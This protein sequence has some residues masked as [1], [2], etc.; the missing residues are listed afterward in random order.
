VGYGNRPLP[1]QEWHR[2]TAPASTRPRQLAPREAEHRALAF[3]ALG[4]DPSPSTGS[5]TTC[6]RCRLHSPSASARCPTTKPPSAPTPACSRPAQGDQL[7]LSF[8]TRLLRA[9]GRSIARATDAPVELYPSTAV[10]SSC[11]TR[12]LFRA[13]GAVVAIVGSLGFSSFGCQQ[14]R[15]RPRAA[16]TTAVQAAANH[17]PGCQAAAGPP[18]G[19]SP[20]LCPAPKSTCQEAAPAACERLIQAC[21]TPKAC[22]EAWTPIA[23]DAG[24]GADSACTDRLVRQMT[25]GGDAIVPALI[26]AART[27]SD[28]AR[29]ILEQTFVAIRPWRG[30]LVASIAAEAPVWLLAHVESKDTAHQLLL[31][32]HD[33]AVRWIRDGLRSG[34]S[35][36]HFYSARFVAARLGS[37]EVIPTMTTVIRD[38]GLRGRS[39]MR[40]L[41]LMERHAI[42]PAIAA[43]LVHEDW[44][45]V[46]E[47]LEVAA[48]TRPAGVRSELRRVAESHWS[49]RLRGHASGVLKLLEGPSAPTPDF[50][51][52]RF[53]HG[54]AHCVPARG[55][56]D[57][58]RFSYRGQV[59][60]R[61]AP[62]WPEPQ[63]PDGFPEACLRSR[64]DRGS[65]HEFPSALTAS[66]AVP[67][68]WLAVVN[69]G[70]W[71]GHVLFVAKD[72]TG[73]ELPNA[74]P[75]DGFVE[76]PDGLLGVYGSCH[77]NCTIGYV[78]RLMQ[79]GGKWQVAQTTTLP[80]VAR[81][82]WR[83]DDGTVLVATEAGIVH[84][85][86]TGTFDFLG[87]L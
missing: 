50:D 32:R 4:D 9:D 33:E 52:S 26:A 2:Q 80:N 56:G 11:M 5:T 65:W 34:S 62:A 42:M 58:W 74:V 51:H 36:W 13:L 35:R 77:G 45:M 84:L 46:L 28:G 20:G 16:R 54:Y 17:V 55:T 57:V 39:I 18:I 29:D 8:R 25:A 1:P 48:A 15:P 22:V 79:R 71:G 76:A 24:A 85:A 59:E 14:P 53:D 69:N 6:D 61:R 7:A 60:V 49:P 27:S 38:G 43:G 63:V 67:D 64:T 72:G 83:E 40:V 21:Q 47:A 23:D 31:R 68:G 10:F 81:G 30:P 41:P 82:A 78:Q 86:P 12:H 66:V 3:H 75:Y 73:Y 37:A 44:G 19:V 87:C 70:E